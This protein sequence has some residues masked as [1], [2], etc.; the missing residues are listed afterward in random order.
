LVAHCQEFE[1]PVLSLDDNER[2]EGFNERSSQLEY[3]DGRVCTEKEAVVSDDG[4]LALKT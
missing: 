2:N 1:H 3:V 4:C